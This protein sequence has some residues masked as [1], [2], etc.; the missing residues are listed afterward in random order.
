M[1][2]SNFYK[3]VLLLLLILF[4]SCGKSDG[5]EAVLPDPDFYIYLCFGQSNMEGGAAIEAIDRAADTRFRV[6]AA[7]DCPN[8]GKEEGF[9]VRCCPASVLMQF[10]TFPRRLF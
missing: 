9:L 10:R 7:L 2:T 6:M 3:P 5:P 8:L 4:S 1:N